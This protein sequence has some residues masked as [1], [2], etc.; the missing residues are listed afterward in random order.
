V[1]L[2]IDNGGLASAEVI[3]EKIRR[4]LVLPPPR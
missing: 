4:V 1:V 2:E 3:L